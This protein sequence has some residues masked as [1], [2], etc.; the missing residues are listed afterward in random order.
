MRR[1]RARA[2]LAVTLVASAALVFAQD[3]AEHSVGDLLKRGT[4]AMTTGRFS[5]AIGFFDSAIDL[6][7]NNYLSY[8]RRATA[9]LSLGRSSAALTDFDE[10]LK[11]NPKFA[12]AHLERAKILTREGELEQAHDAV[13]A[14]LVNKKEDAE[15]KELQASIDAALKN[16][17]SVH[18]AH[19]SVMSAVQKG[20]QPATDSS[21][22]RSIDECQR[23]AGLVLDTAPS[24]LGVRR[25]RADCLVAKGEFQD[26]MADW[27]RIAHLSPSPSLLLRLSSLSYYVFGEQESQG[28]DAG[29]A[30]LKTCLASDPDNRECSKAHKR[31]KNIDKALKKA[32]KF[33]ESSSWR[34]A[35]SALKGTK[36]G[37]PTIIEDTEKAIRED[38]A[39]RA[40]G[41]ESVLPPLL[42]DAAQRSAL[43]LELNEIHCQA[44][45]ELGEIKKATPFCD[46]VLGKEEDNKIGRIGRGERHMAEDNYEEGV[47]DFRKAFEASGNQDASIHSRLQKAE[48]KLK[49]SKSKDYYKVLG[50]SKTADD[51]TIKKAYRQKAREHH[52]DKG[53]SPEK[54]AEINEAF[55]VL[56]DAELRARF[57]AGDDPNDPMGGQQ[58]SQG[59]PFAQGFGPQFVSVKTVL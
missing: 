19:N 20:K 5:D 25:I 48:R 2:L 6:E 53:G 58:G 43:L 12:K 39:P 55:D 1:I 4:V 45:T 27:T 52:P 38:L 37:G 54:M 50:V 10:I 31:L 46:A 11:L 33:R 36:V 56:K 3:H 7:P 29:L 57:D 21:L 9:Q 28:R 23:N 59:N 24:M 16:V 51:K 18:K 26:A 15:A 14:Y 47:R 42:H 41:Q 32:N 22:A 49:L 17:K 13:K 40:D 34:A 8:Y 44:H 35:L 30:H